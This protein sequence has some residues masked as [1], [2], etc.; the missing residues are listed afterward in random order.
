MSRPRSYRTEGVVLKSTT[1]GEAGL[2]LTF[3]TRD[4][5]KLKAVV[6]GAR[7]PTSKLAGHLQLLNRVEMEMGSARSSGIDA[8]SQAQVAESFPGLN[9]SL[10][11]VSRGIYL[12]ELVDG[13]GAEGSPNIEL[14]SLLLDALRT[15]DSSPEEEFVLR[16]FELHLLRCSGFMPEL[17]RCVECGVELAPGDHRFSPELGG[18]VCTRCNPHGVRMMHLS[19]QAIKVLR[20]FERCQPSEAIKLRVPP[21]LREELQGLLLAA[22]KYWLDK[23]IQS[24]SFMEHLERFAK[25]GV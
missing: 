7:K 9:A 2:L 11:G 12:A 17:Y 3:Y 19:L 24:K 14:Y 4:H 1:S 10:P 18:T 21:T 16:H 15:L 25:T 13:F 23:E 8:V 22:L 5:G 20:F 6:S